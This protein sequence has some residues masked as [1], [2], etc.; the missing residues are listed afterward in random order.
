[1]NGLCLLL[2]QG[3]VHKGVKIYF[4]KLKYREVLHRRVEKPLRVNRG[5]GQLSL[6]AHLK[7][8]GIV[9]LSSLIEDAEFQT[10]EQ[11]CI[12]LKA[13]FSSWNSS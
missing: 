6:S 1:M 4:R 9:C 13:H 10:Q 8:C 7:W 12:G 2:L 3:F 11:Y 5:P